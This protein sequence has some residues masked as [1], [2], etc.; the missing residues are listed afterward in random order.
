MAG[1]R[2]EEKW[3]LV[4]SAL[5]ERRE[6]LPTRFGASLVRVRG[7]VVEAGMVDGR[8]L[9]DFRLPQIETWQQQAGQLV[10]IQI[11]KPFFEKHI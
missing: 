4:H 9:E 5:E 10:L 8:L 2:E 6:G 3:E 1:R 11:D 7:A